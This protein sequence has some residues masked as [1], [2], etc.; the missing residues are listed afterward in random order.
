MTDDR[1]LVLDFHVFYIYQEQSVIQGRNQGM[2]GMGV[3]DKVSKVVFVRFAQPLHLR[4][5]WTAGVAIAMKFS[6]GN[7]QEFVS[8]WTEAWPCCSVELGKADH[9]DPAVPQAGP[10]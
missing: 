6:L 5:Q 7:H 3:I 9:A 8:V 10:E 1:D 4:M 2:A